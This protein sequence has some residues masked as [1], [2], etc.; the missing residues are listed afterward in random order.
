[1]VLIRLKEEM[2]AYIGK[3][4]EKIEVRGRKGRGRPKKRWKD[5]IN[6]D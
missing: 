6:K 3:R 5:Y 1:V 4:V 2:R